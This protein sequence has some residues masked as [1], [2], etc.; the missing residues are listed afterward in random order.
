MSGPI[1]AGVVFIVVIFVI[2]AA[3]I[4]SR[5]SMYNTGDLETDTSPLQPGEEYYYQDW[6]RNTKHGM[7][8]G[9]EAAVTAAPL[10][11]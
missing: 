11:L 8:V 4:F 3:L 5:H 6:G 1:I 7:K 9:A 10:M 2:T